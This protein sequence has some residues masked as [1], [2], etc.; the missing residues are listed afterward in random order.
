MNL[1]EVISEDGLLGV[2]FGAT[3]SQ[4]VEAIGPPEDWR[5][6][7]PTILRYGDLQL[8]FL[9]SGGLWLATI[10]NVDDR[11]RLHS[12]DIDVDWRVTVERLLAVLSGAGL[13]GP[14]F[15]QRSD[16]LIEMTG[17][18]FRAEGVFDDSGL[19]EKLSLVWCSISDA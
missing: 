19:L 10:W 12:D 1:E 11:L 3:H 17:P 6:A 8:T 16:R 9:E 13:D 5:D 7:T 18:H 2:P 4:V 15:D 14:S